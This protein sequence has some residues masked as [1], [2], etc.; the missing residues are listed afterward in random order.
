MNYKKL[1]TIVLSSNTPKDTIVSS[2]VTT[3]NK[4][5]TDKETYIA[6]ASHVYEN[7]E[8]AG[9]NY[10]IV[11]DY[12]K[13]LKNLESN[14][15]TL[16]EKITEEKIKQII[17]E[18]PNLTKEEINELVANK[19]SDSITTGEI[20][21]AIDQ[22]IE[23][24]G[25]SIIPQEPQ[26]ENPD[27][28]YPD[29]IESGAVFGEF[30]GYGAGMA[31]LPE[32]AAKMGLTP[33]SGAN[34]ITN[35]NFGNFSATDGSIFC[36]IPMMY[37]KA[38]KVNANTEFGKPNIEISYK[39]KKGF[40]PF[41]AFKKSDGNYVKCVFVAK[42]TISKS[43]TKAI[44]VKSG[45]PLSSN[46]SYNGIQQ[47]QLNGK[48]VTA[49]NLGFFDAVKTSNSNY[50]LH[51]APLRFVYYMTAEAHI[52]AAAKKFGSRTQ[53]PTTICAW[54]DIEPYFPKGN[55]TKWSDINDTNLKFTAASSNTYQ[56]SG[57]YGV[58]KTGSGSNFAK[59]THNGQA[60]GIADLNGN[61]WEIDA[62]YINES[63]V[64]YGLKGID[65]VNILTPSNYNI[66]SNYTPLSTT[67]RASAKDGKW[68]SADIVPFSFDGAI[69]DNFL[70]ALE[71]G[72]SSNANK[73]YGEDYYYYLRANYSPLFGGH[74]SNGVH[75]GLLYFHGN[76]NAWSG[77]SYH[78]SCRTI[79]VPK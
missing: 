39:T 44:S 52:Q 26:E 51:Y 36:C 4:K 8:N 50:S 72:I 57:N 49:N 29:D 10:F 9:D 71:G 66:V 25:G 3:L 12:L 54:A 16:P 5:T 70:L 41:Y 40:Y 43:G 7:G 67:G 23:D 55:N 58:A 27:K 24:A 61:I 15:I 59:T 47:L 73:K 74:C 14:V 46:S 32:E 65:L 28:P 63:N 45:D 13:N 64:L 11:S 22:A 37:Y 76:V 17:A 56:S 38:D 2:T 18:N 21:S 78:C 6:E 77:S 30:G 69:E 20:K 48:A 1:D 62:G 68:E 31:Y 19:I 42:Y 60:C 35:P 33:L 79:V 75:A 53:I 34:D